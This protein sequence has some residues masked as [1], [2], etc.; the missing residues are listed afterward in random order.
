MKH[1]RPLLLSIA[2]FCLL[3]LAIALYLQHGHGMLPCPYCVIQRY[4][5]L[6]VT[7]LALLGVA[8]HQPKI[9]AGVCLTLTLGGLGVAAKHLYVLANPGLSCGID[10]KEAFLNKLPT[11]EYIPTIFHADGLCEGA[12]AAVLGLTVP[13]WTLAAWIVVAVSMVWILTRRPNT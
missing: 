10:P 4:L 2:F 5:F 1:T 3:A 12:T 13:Q 6:G 7:V 11:A 9:G 8:A